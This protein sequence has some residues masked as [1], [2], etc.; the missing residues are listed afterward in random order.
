[1]SEHINYRVRKTADNRGGAAYCA[2]VDGPQ[3]RAPGLCFMHG[4]FSR[5]H[6]IENDEKHS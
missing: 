6:G 4:F 2:R 1:M 3:W 5:S